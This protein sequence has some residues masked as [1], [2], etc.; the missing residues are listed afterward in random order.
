MDKVLTQGKSQIEEFSRQFILIKPDVSP[1]DIKAAVTQGIASQPT[2]SRY[3]RGKVADTAVA[4]KLLT[5]FK[6]QINSRAGA[7]L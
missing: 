6:G 5:F 2:I 7:L 3:L 4:Y 1:E